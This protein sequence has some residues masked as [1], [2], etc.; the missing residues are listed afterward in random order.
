[1]P[2]SRLTRTFELTGFAN[3]AWWFAA[4]SA[5]RQGSGLEDRDVCARLKRPQLNANRSA[6][7]ATGR[8]EGQLTS[9]RDRRGAP[10][11]SAP[12]LR[13]LSRQQ[14]ERW[15]SRSYRAQLASTHVR[16]YS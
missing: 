8:Y 4:L 13:V 11:S 1:M 3:A 7:V 14:G 5:P 12:I 10:Q 2:E 6:E 16:V 9:M 15:R